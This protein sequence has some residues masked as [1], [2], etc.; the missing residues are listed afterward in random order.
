[1]T[2]QKATEQA[3]KVKTERRSYLLSEVEW[4][5]DNGANGWDLERAF[6]KS[7]LHS[8]ERTAYRNGDKQLAARIH[9]LWTQTRTAA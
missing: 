9:Q 7:S 5:I 3:A 6:P 4:L 2:S 8:L 1:M